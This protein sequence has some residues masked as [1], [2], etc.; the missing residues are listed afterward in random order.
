MDNFDFE[1]ENYDLIPLDPVPSLTTKF[2]LFMRGYLDNISYHAHT[3][4]MFM[5]K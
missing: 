4:T 1:T 2:H 3:A 5:M